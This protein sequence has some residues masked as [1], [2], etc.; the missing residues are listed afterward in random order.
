M[1]PSASSSARQ[2][3]SHVSKINLPHPPNNIP[4][5]NPRPPTAPPYTEI[6]KVQPM[7][8]SDKQHEANIR[9][10]QHSTGPK[11]E[12]GK[13]AVRMNALTWGLRAKSFLITGEDPAEYK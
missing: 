11:T 5:R 12:E 7:L 3:R 8:V 10:A 13:A 1:P 4:A 2:A 6:G 9:N